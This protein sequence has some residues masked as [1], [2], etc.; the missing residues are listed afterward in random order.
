MYTE[1][2]VFS[3]VGVGEQDSPVALWVLL[4]QHGE[5]VVGFCGAPLSRIE[6]EEVIPGLVVLLIIGILAGKSVEGFL[7]EA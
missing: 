5:T 2:L 1:T 4:L 3:K 7:A 6:Q